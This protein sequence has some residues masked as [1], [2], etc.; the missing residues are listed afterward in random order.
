MCR[1]AVEKP[2]RHSSEQPYDCYW[3]FV[4][5][6]TQIL[7]KK[8]QRPNDQPETF[9]G[10]QINEMLTVRT[11]RTMPPSPLHGRRGLG[12]GGVKQHEYD[13][14]PLCPQ[15]SLPGHRK[16]PPSTRSFGLSACAGRF[17][18]AR[19]DRNA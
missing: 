7:C 17:A 1:D 19:P 15:R 11:R 6:S 12:A 5:E 9:F 16:L 13:N 18:H 2:H 3:L 14:H 10:L 8:A 4:M